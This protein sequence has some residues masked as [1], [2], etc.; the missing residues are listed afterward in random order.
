MKNTTG[1]RLI[2]T[3]FHH[4]GYV[5]S[6]AKNARNIPLLRK[7]LEEDPESLLTRLQIIESGEQEADY[8]DQIREALA[9]MEK[10]PN[11]WQNLGAPTIRHAVIAAY[12]YKL[13]EFEQWADQIGRASCRERV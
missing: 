8:L 4:D 6:A 13:P 10:K 2:K 3:V 5:A 11:G 1:I 12:K 9:L 7:K